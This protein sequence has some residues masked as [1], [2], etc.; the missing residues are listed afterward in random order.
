MVVAEAL[1][2]GCLWVLQRLALRTHDT[3]AVVTSQL[4]GNAFGRIVPGGGAAAAALQYRMLVQRGHAGR[5]TRRA[6]RLVAARLRRCSRCPLSPC[7]RSSA[8]RSRRAS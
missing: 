4:A 3:Y 7:R 6:D 2:F 5:A 8:A 1:S